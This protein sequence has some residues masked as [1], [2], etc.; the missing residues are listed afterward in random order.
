MLYARKELQMNEYYSQESIIGT[1]FRGKLIS[2]RRVGE[3]EAFVPEIGGSAYIVGTNISMIDS[4]DPLKL[5]F[6]LS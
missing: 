6:A 1:V 3:Y 2:S 4:R 5:G